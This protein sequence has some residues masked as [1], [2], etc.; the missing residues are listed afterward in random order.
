MY[1]Y[2]HDLGLNA[3][4]S[5]CLVCPNEWEGWH[6]LD[7]VIDAPVYR[8]V[9]TWEWMLARPFWPPKSSTFYGCLQ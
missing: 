2:E 3:K 8:D 4:T 9:L 6:V 7:R 1:L 5:L